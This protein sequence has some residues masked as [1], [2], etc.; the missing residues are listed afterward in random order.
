MI[1]LLYRSCEPPTNTISEAVIND[2]KLSSLFP[3]SVISIL[4]TPVNSELIRFRQNIFKCLENAD[5]YESLVKLYMSLVSLKRAYDMITQEQS[6]VEKLFRKN[7]ALHVYMEVAEC[8]CDASNYIPFMKEAFQYWETPEAEQAIMRI[9]SCLDVS[10]NE[11]KKIACFDVFLGDSSKLTKSDSSPTIVDNLSKI[12]FGWKKNP[13]I[14]TNSTCHIDEQLSATLVE[15]FSDEIG[16]M[17]TALNCYEDIDLC[18]LLSY[19]PEIDF[20]ITITNFNRKV[21][22]K[23]ISTCY[24]KISPRRRYN[25]RNICDISLFK[26]TDHIVCNDIDLGEDDSFFFL[27]GANGGGKTSFLRALGINLILFMCG[28]PIYAEDAVIFPFTQIFTHFPANEASDSGKFLEEVIR[29]EQIFNLADANSFILFNET[30]SGTDNQKGIKGIKT[31][32]SAVVEKSMFGIYVTHFH[33]ICLFSSAILS[34]TIDQ[35]NNRLFKIVRSYKSSTSHA[36]DI[37]K[38]YS[39]DYRSLQERS[40]Q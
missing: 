4:S 19:I 15:E 35:Y 26:T 25:A 10:D 8:I 17:I 22:N 11:I 28:C 1:S 16:N 18:S 6:I 20:Y 3:S 13:L 12:M 9:A 24:P 36:Q 40:E 33:E 32:Y 5:A 37:L 30:F 21:K 29:V 27:V 14:K 7:Y 34:A 38:K 23:K 39:I 31:I 2:L